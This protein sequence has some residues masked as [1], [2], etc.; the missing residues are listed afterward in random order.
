[1]KY[2]AF[3]FFILFSFEALAG[4]VKVFVSL[5]PQ[6]YFV[7][8]IGGDRVS[9]NV[10]VKPGQSPE[11]FEPSPKLMSLYSRA[12]VYFTIGMPFERVWI[13]RVTSLNQTI[14]IKSTQP[15]EKK[16]LLAEHEHHGENDANWDPHTWLSPV[17][18]AE[19]AKII[20]LELSRIS[21]KD[22]KLFLNNYSKLKDEL[23]VLDDFISRR[24]KASGKKNF[25]TFHPAF[26][27]FAEQ[28]ELNQIAIEVGGKEPSAKQITRIVERIKNKNVS[29]ILIERQ[30]NQLIPKTIADSVNAELL[31]LDPLAFDYINN[32]QDMAEKINKALF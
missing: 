25:I 31:I 20:M 29:Y 24:F 14:S 26:S 8:R 4:T 11:T 16:L 1:M 9:V 2:I 22:K 7:Q 27:Y 19:Q 12:D 28:Y 15:D 21:P 23:N 30:F 13:N 18:A 3:I 6:Q 17:I 5:L 32:M 10:M